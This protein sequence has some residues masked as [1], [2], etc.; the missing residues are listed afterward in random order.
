MKVKGVSAEVTNVN[1]RKENGEDGLV[2][3]TDVSCKF[4]VPRAVIDALVPGG[5]YTGQ[6]YSGEE[7]RLECLYPIQY[8]PKIEGLRVT[9]DCG[10]HPMVFEPARIAGGMKLTPQMGQYIQ[11]QCKIQVH[12]DRTDSGRLDDAVKE[13]VT[14]TIEPIN[15][16]WVAQ[17][18]EAESD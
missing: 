14:L 1:P 16:D 12:P 3:A 4:V 5:D 17:V 8:Q 11:V 7:T 13:F 15:D 2:L 6:F 18:E 10:V 9:V